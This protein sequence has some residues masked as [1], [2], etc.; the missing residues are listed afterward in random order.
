MPDGYTLHRG[1]SRLT[2]DPIVVLLTFDSQNTKTGDMA[3]TWILRDD[4]HPREAIKRGDDR[5]ICG[6]CVHRGNQAH[7]PRRSC[8]VMVGFRPSS[9]YRRYLRGDYPA[10]PP[11]IWSAAVDGRAVRLGAYGDPVA[12]PLSLWQALVSRARGWTGYTHQWS[13]VLADGFQALLMASCDSLME[14]TTARA[15]GWRTFRV[16]HHD[17]GLWPGEITC[18]ASEEAGKRTTCARCL[19]CD[20]TR[21]FDLGRWRKSIAILPHGQFAANFYRNRHQLDLLR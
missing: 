5:A 1:P 9:V 13:T 4:M 8:Y 19:L 21:P 7:A 3:Q 18:P 12:A 14:M 10:A 16:R 17:G 11:S 6:D 20:G 15:L 2:G